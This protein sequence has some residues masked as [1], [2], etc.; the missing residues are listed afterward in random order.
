MDDDYTVDEA[1]SVIEKAIDRK[2]KD[3]AQYEKR[4]NRMRKPERKADMEEMIKYLTADMNSYLSVLADMKDDESL[5]EGI[6]LDAEELDCPKDYDAYMASLDADALENELDADQVR[7]DYCEAVLDEICYVVG[8]QALKSKRMVKVLRKNEDIVQMIG[9][10]I[11]SDED[12]YAELCD[13]LA[14]KPKKKKK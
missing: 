11:Y 3:I 8:Y 5:I 10:A 13:I 6:D 2:K 1:I 4:R 14:S 9:E 12:L 7:T